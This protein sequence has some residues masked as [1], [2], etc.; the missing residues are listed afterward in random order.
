MSTV[1]EKLFENP[2]YAKFLEWGKLISLTGGTQA[3]IQGIGLISGIIVIRMLP[4]EEYAYYTIANTMLGTMTVLADSGISSGVMTQGGK[5]WQ[6][7][8]KLGVVI[9]TGLKLRRKFAL[10]SILVTMPILLYLLRHHNASWPTSIL[11]M[12]CVLPAFFSALSDTILQIAPKLHQ[13]IKPL[14][15][16]QLNVSIFRVILNGFLIFIF[17]LTF[18]ALLASGIPRAVGNIKLRSISS[19]Y[20]YINSIPDLEAKNGIL[21]VVKKAM[22][23]A[24]YYCISGQITIWLVSI[25]GSTMALASLGALGRIT[26]V[27]SIMTISFST[28]VTPRFAR[29]KSNKIEINKFFLR[30]Q[31]LLV[32]VSILIVIIVFV[33]SKYILLILGNEYKNLNYE[34]LLITISGCIGFI[35][36]ITN[37]LLSSRGLIVPP[38]IFIVLMIFVQTGFIF[39]FSVNELEG[40]ILYSIATSLAIYLIRVI[41]FY[42]ESKAV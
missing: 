21:K 3:L 35:S 7:K 41:H 30:V 36:L 23:I 17:P 6:N 27:M 14:Q 8:E 42:I 22:P 37:S 15:K 25:F 32:L 16:N 20:I 13:A 12:I 10:A 4:T 9:A 11:I 31:I 29:L 24:I 5:V 26:A 38:T 1:T 33:S 2:T 34:L 39:I 28:L 18:V 19:K 40:V